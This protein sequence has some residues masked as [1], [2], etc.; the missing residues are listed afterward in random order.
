MHIPVC[1][2]AVHGAIY[3]P[4]QASAAA[5]RVAVGSVECRGVS[6]NPPWPAAAAYRQDLHA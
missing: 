2:H 6:P 1:D 5:V 4:V 3:E